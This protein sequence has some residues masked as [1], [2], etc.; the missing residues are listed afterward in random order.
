MKLHLHSLM[1]CSDVNGPGRRSVVWVQGCSLKCHGCWNPETHLI[2]GTFYYEVPALVQ[3]LATASR[4]IRGE[5]ITIS[6]GEPMEQALAI[7]ELMAQIRTATPQLSIGLFS[8]YSERELN[9]GQFP[10]FPNEDKIH[11]RA[12]WRR[13]RSHLDFAVLGRYN[14]HQSISDPLTTSRNQRLRLLSGRYTAADF[15][16]QTVEVTID[17]AGLTQITGFPVLG[18]PSRR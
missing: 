3:W 14:R 17:G 10:G 18:S 4:R 13:I 15:A 2:G 6:G 8:G 5:G 16:P 11:K 12:L 1:A 7:L 9:E